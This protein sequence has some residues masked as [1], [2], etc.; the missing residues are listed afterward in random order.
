MPRC[1]PLSS[2]LTP[3]R[4]ALNRR[5]N[6]YFPVMAHDPLPPAPA[7]RVLFS[8]LL[9]SFPM[10]SLDPCWGFLRGSGLLTLSLFVPDA[11]SPVLDSSV[12]LNLFASLTILYETSRAIVLISRCKI[13]QYARRTNTYTFFSK[14]QHE[15]ARLL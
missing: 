14:C 13:D 3:L 5:R 9:A 1:S 4:T 8:S 12:G 7:P 10:L 2:L 11:V 6:I 15:N